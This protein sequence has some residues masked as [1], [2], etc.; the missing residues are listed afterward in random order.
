VED[1]FPFENIYVLLM[2]I[3]FPWCQYIRN[4]ILLFIF[5]LNRPV[6]NIYLELGCLS[7]LMDSSLDDW[8]SIP[9]RDRDIF[10][11]HHVKIGPGAHIVSNLLS[12]MGPHQEKAAGA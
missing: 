1:L 5:G 11:F 3:G 9:G 12:T 8:V 10:M 4:R 7:K 2:V 6:S